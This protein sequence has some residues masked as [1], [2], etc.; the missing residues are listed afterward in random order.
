M[1]M[2]RTCVDMDL[3]CHNGV[4]NR[5]GVEEKTTSCKLYGTI[6]LPFYLPYG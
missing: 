6:S 4:N 3:N 1:C 5:N 2:V